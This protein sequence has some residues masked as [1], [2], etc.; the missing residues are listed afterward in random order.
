MPVVA[1]QIT[2]DATEQQIA[3]ALALAETVAE[4]GFRGPDPY[5]GLLWPWP[6]VLVAALSEAV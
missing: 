2:R 6:G 4:A 1:E 3:T 5:D